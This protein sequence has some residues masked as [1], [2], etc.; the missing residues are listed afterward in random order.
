MNNFVLVCHITLKWKTLKFEVVRV[1]NVKKKGDEYK[2]SY[3]GVGQ[4][5]DVTEVRMTLL[6]SAVKLIQFNSRLYMIA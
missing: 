1:Q 4:G 2:A 5:Y 3:A 6:F